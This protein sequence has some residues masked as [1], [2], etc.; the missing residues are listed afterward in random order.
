MLKRTQPAGNYSGKAST[1]SLAADL[2]PTA[3]TLSNSALT[4]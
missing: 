3:G 4:D 1:G 2:V